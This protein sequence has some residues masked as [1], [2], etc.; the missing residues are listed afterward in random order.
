MNIKEAR[1]W[2]NRKKDETVERMVI[3]KRPKK[4]EYLRGLLSG[5]DDTSVVIDH[6]YWQAKHE[7]E[8]VMQK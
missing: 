7:P 1:I 8:K 4:R 5:Y 6:L 3:E 2:I